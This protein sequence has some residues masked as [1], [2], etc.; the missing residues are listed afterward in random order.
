MWHLMHSQYANAMT[1]I[2]QQMHIVDT[3]DPNHNKTNRASLKIAQ[4]ATA[5]SL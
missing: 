4:L 3:D 2:N 1:G 5:E